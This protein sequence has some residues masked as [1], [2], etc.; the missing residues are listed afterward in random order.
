MPLCSHEASDGW[1]FVSDETSGFTRANLEALASCSNRSWFE[2][3][4]LKESACSQ[5]CLRQLV[6]TER[7]GI[8]GWRSVVV[9]Q[10]SY[11]YF[12]LKKFARTGSG[13]FGAEDVLLYHWRHLPKIPQENQVK[14][15]NSVLCSGFLSGPEEVPIFE[16]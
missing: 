5:L 3:H 11:K 12:L 4:G 16:T 7:L 1:V 14:N 15:G 6:S 9:N 2:A 13:G 8:S 10:G